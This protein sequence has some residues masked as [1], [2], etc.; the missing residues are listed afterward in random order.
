[1]TF[2]RDDYTKWV[3]KAAKTLIDYMAVE[4]IDDREC[5][6]ADDG[7]GEPAMRYRLIVSGGSIESPRFFVKCAKRHKRKAL[8]GGDMWESGDDDAKLIV[9]GR[10]LIAGR[11]KLQYRTG[12]GKTAVMHVMEAPSIKRLIMM[13]KSACP[14]E[15]WASMSSLFLLKTG[16]APPDLSD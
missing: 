3:P 7:L 8:C 9:E 14:E 10:S 2:V 15:M 6:Y 12:R 5:A 16:F 4:G 11:A 1:M 13:A